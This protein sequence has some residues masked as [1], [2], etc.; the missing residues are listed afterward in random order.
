MGALSVAIACGSE[1][2]GGGSGGSGAGSGGSGGTGGGDP[3][4]AQQACNDYCHKVETLGCPIMG[5]CMTM[6]DGF[7]ADLPTECED[8]V[9]AQFA[10]GQANMPTCEDPVGC[11]DEAAAVEACEAM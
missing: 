9:V 3:V 6:C 4:T 11:D 2:N 5:D 8:E 1:V 10:C 7:L